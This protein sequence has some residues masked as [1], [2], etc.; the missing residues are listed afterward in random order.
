MN[1]KTKRSLIK[2]RWQSRVPSF[3]GGVLLTLAPGYIAAMCPND[4]LLN[5]PSPYLFSPDVDQ[6]LNQIINDVIGSYNFLSTPGGV[7]LNKTLTLV[8][9]IDDLKGA[10]YDPH[11]GEVVL[12]G[13]GEVTSIQEQIDMHDFIVAVRTV[14]SVDAEGKQIDPGISFGEINLGQ[15]TIDGKMVAEYR[16]ATR[17][18]NF[19]QV[20]F[21]AD[22]ILKK[23]GQ[24]VDEN[25]NMLTGYAVPESV[26][27]EKCQTV[28][29][30]TLATCLGY[31]GSAER[32]ITNNISFAGYSY[33]YLI[34]PAN[35][36]L[37]MFS[38]GAGANQDQSFKF[39]DVS[40]Q[41]CFKIYQGNT[42]ITDSL[43]P[44]D[45]V[46]GDAQGQA[47]AF[48][49]NITQHYDAYAEIIE[50]HSAT[51]GSSPLKKLKRLAKIVGL[52]RWLRD[53]NVPVDLSF[54]EEYT[55]PEIKTPRLANVLQI[56][57]DGAGGIIPAFSGA[58]TGGCGENGV[59]II[60][61]VRYNE[62]NSACD[63]TNPVCNDSTFLDDGANV[64]VINRETYDQMEWSFDSEREIGS[65]IESF[66]AYG[67]TVSP[68][69]KDG[70][71]TFTAHG[72]SYPNLGG[73]SLGITPRYNAFS[74]STDVFALARGWS[75]L[76]FE[77]SFPE[78]VGFFC[79]DAG[80]VEP[81]DAESNPQGII[82]QSRINIIDNISSRSLI[83]DLAGTI[84]LIDGATTV[85]R[86]YYISS[87]TNDWIYEHPS[88]EFIYS[89]LNKLDQPT[90]VVWFKRVVGSYNAYKAVPSYIIDGY[91]EETSSNVANKS[92][93]GIWT[94]YNYD[95]KNHLIAIEGNNGKRINID[96][97]AGGISRAWYST[98]S[99]VRDVTF[100]VIGNELKQTTRSSGE[101]FDYVYAIPG[102][103]GPPFQL[104]DA[105][106]NETLILSGPD[107]E[108][109]STYLES[110]SNTALAQNIVYDRIPSDRSTDEGL[111][112]TYSGVELSKTVLNKTSDGRSSTLYKDEHGRLK[113][114]V[115]KAQVNT[116]NTLQSIH[117]QY[118]PDP[119][120]SSNRPLS[121][122][123]PRG[124]MTKY[125]YDDSG[126]ITSITD[127]RSTLEIP[128]IKRIDR[129]FDSA[130]VDVDESGKATYKAGLE[131][132][133]LEVITDAK[134]RKSANKYDSAGRL[135][136][137]YR[138]INVTD[139][140]INRDIDGKLT[141]EF[142]FTF[143]YG[144]GYAVN[145]LYDPASGKLA[146]VTNTASELSGKYPWISA[147]DSVL[148]TRRNSY[149]Q[150]ENVQ[151][152]AGYETTYQY[153]GLARL[154]SVQGPADSQAT[155]LNY[156]DQGL[157]QDRLS[158]IE[159]S[160]GK[161]EQSH[162]VINRSETT[163]NPQGVATTTFYNN[164]GNI[165]RV[166]EISPDASS[167][168]T[169]QYFYDEFGR[170]DYKLMPNETRVNYTY[171]GFDRL[172]SISELEEASV[173]STNA[174]PVF[175]TVPSG[176]TTAPVGSEYSFTMAASDANADSLNYYLVG[177][178]EGMSIDPITA[179][180]TWTPTGDQVGDYEVVVQVVDANGGVDTIT[181]IITA[182]ESDPVGDNCVGVSNP[183]QRDTDGD[184]F[185]NY[186]DPDLNNDG[187]VN[188]ADLAAFK[189]IFGLGIIS[190]D[191]SDHADFNG[192][193]QVDYDDLDILRAY[194]GKAP[195]ASGVAQ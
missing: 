90:K 134:G 18:T 34:E 95:L 118:A 172:Q 111:G 123:D 64:P 186:C 22:Y 159:T 117:Y 100:S 137:T 71:I 176:T 60:G 26:K 144:F 69:R 57:H 78:S 41:V 6:N 8:N 184:G 158:A 21:D 19:G 104:I 129:G 28:I 148:V 109:R 167:V 36:E 147:N 51:D 143:G 108:N 15:S 84:D 79:E 125:L 177:A 2:S 39:I 181:F 107:L 195:G 140:V 120:V 12:I 150:A 188:F 187:V 138:R 11:R 132:W 166:V 35:I 170:L 56:C 65:G 178:P 46:S 110:N 7:D 13:Q 10:V 89:R 70:G 29:N 131:G 20:L 175:V 37:A 58:F 112:A 44:G 146:S 101:K 93:S 50:L 86:P 62:E 3:F 53:N 75:I 160:L 139:Q 66:N 180:I 14:Y 33:Q 96:Y 149:G 98:A 43:C 153:D 74:N 105:T 145:Y 83:F 1:N 157:A 72:L 97:N 165:E 38:D 80:G 128:R 194:F 76:P 103:E 116:Q 67:Q 162:D 113:A 85:S 114:A 174:A 136:T 5:E 164:Q 154:V 42:E 156:N 171:D 119:L 40:M 185:G 161:T 77:M 91:Q 182:G 87:E 47:M 133:K 102:N 183:D 168:L 155:S 61:G 25:G 99:G 82:A 142:I 73:H 152:A 45:A 121:I 52:V 190:G 16:G 23:L 81:C 130:D 192:S 127:P 124:S 17:D 54:M 135:I 191:M 59:M 193:G 92:N 63:L 179:V 49:E 173:P 126:R 189:K 122:T 27:S 32:F 115:Y 9:D 169:T 163:T 68:S 24:G 94:Q 141:D 106:R 30:P 151:S 4:A 88:G 55:P 48:S 31:M